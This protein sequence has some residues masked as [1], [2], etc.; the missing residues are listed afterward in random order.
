M[1]STLWRG[2]LGPVVLL[3]FCVPAWADC[4]RHSSGEIY[5]GAG[6]CVRDRGGTIWCSRFDDGAAVIAR[7][8]T[9][10]CGRGQCER[11]SAGEIICSSEI[12]GAVLRDSRGRVRCYKRCEAAAAGNC[13]STPADGGD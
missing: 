2:L 13:E 5:C 3:V 12:R 7:D 4:M 1:S 9:V 10:L 11:T 6:Q 8:G